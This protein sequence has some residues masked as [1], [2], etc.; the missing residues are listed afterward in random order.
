MPATELRREE[1][2]HLDEVELL[3]DT[4]QNLAP[5]CAERKSKAAALWVPP[6]KLKKRRC[7][8]SSSKELE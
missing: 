1:S 7:V 6:K 3:D 4:K 5:I 8:V 2:T